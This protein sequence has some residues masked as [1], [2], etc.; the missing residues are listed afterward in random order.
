MISEKE[1]Y[2][3]KELEAKALQKCNSEPIQIPGLIQGYG[4]LLVFDFDSLAITYTSENIEEFLELP[5]ELYKLT[6]RDIFSSEDYHTIS[7][8]ASHQ[9][10][11]TQREYV[12]TLKSKQGTLEL[13][14]YRTENNVALELIPKQKSTSNIN[15]NSHVKWVLDQVKALDTVDEIL[16][17][18]VQSLQAITQFDR[19]M[20][21]KFHPDDSGEVVA[22][23]NNNKMDSYLGLRFPAYDIPPIARELYMKLSI[24]Y[25]YNSHKESKK[26]IK[27]DHVKAPLDQSLGILRGTSPVHLQ[28]LR[29]MGVKASASLPI[30]IRGRLWGLFAHH[31][32]EEKIISS[33]ISYSME[34]IGQVLSMVLEQKI[35]YQVEQ[36]ITS[37]QL[38]GDDF[39]TI[40]QN[41]LYPDVFWKNYASK[42]KELIKCDG[43]VYQIDDEIMSFGHCPEKSAI[44]KLG[45][46]L[47]INNEKP[48]YQTTELT[49]FGLGA[50]G[51]AR[52]VLALQINEENPKIAIYFF[53]NK[54]LQHI[55]WAGDPQKNVIVEKTGVR[56]HPRS[57]FNHF[58]ELVK[59]Q[60]E[61][62]DS[63]D[64]ILA[65]IA[66]QKFKNV[67]LNKKANSDR[68]KVIVQEL[69]HRIRN[70]LGLVRAIS[71][72]SVKEGKS[73]DGYVDTLEKRILALA[74]ANNLLTS[75]IN[76]S[77]VIKTLIIQV[78]KPLHNYPGN[79][80]LG[81][82][83]VSISPQ[84]ATTVV[85][86]FHELTT[87]AV[88]YGSLSV[89]KGILQISWKVDPNGLTIDWKELDGPPV[90]APTKTGFG[91]NIIESA[92][93]YEFGGTSKVNFEPDGLHAQITIPMD[94]IGEKE[95][96]LFALEQVKEASMNVDHHKDDRSETNIL[97][98]EDDFINAQEMKRMVHMF[99]VDT[100][101]TFPNQQKALQAMESTQFH[102]AL[103]DVNLK[104][105]T[106]IKVALE[107][108][109]RRIPFIYITGY[110]SSFLK[111]GGFPLASVMEKPI[112]IEKL[113]Q[114]M[115]QSILS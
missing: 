80:K 65:D 48:I 26:I 54:V 17:L 101:A 86:I 57:S 38:E 71:K 51:N 55:R 62:W 41:K 78:I 103:L 92:I 87:N 77:V 70:I 75:H 93:S 112:K 39:I 89:E 44:K 30:I 10:A 29:N 66:Q 73:I 53:R 25:I 22:E 19:V 43:V 113:K 107:C 56:L 90:Q 42:L 91:L 23:A 37:L 82:D 58:K 63:E 74:Q 8:V 28:Y 12:K 72:H 83:D 102:L 14:L 105:E 95:N 32:Q 36:R 18:T 68:L 5:N 69:N 50:L 21:Y 85:L 79:I 11:F 6:V 110:G 27:S 88:K 96:N 84:I 111:E 76:A 24:R 108:V 100:V 9:S 52:G 2:N 34:L 59:D 16:Q 4:G 49:K 1:I 7:N 45:K 47:R 104:N 106:C 64:M 61:I 99:S 20:A 114:I 98:L 60:S 46:Q 94:F 40:N 3:S 115:Y 13:S 33:D 97:I 67:L 31:H 81:G 15:I 109:K 35:K